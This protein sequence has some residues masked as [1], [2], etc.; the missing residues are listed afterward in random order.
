MGGED[1]W[2]KLQI[3]AKLVILRALVFDSNRVQ[4]EKISFRSIFYRLVCYLNLVNK[5]LADEFDEI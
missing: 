5:V 3:T 4:R 1:T 2:G